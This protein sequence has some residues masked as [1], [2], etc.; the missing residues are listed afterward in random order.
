MFVYVVELND[1]IG[2]D[3]SISPD[4]VSS[5][6][7]SQQTTRPAPN[8]HSY[9]VKSPSRIPLRVHLPNEHSYS[10]SD[11][12]VRKSKTDKVE[13]RKKD[14]QFSQKFNEKCAKFSKLCFSYRG[15]ENQCISND[16]LVALQKS[17]QQ[18]DVNSLVSCIFSSSTLRQA[19]VNRQ[20]LDIQNTAAKL[21]RRKHFYVSELMKKTFQDLKHLDWNKIV[22]EMQ[23]MFPDLF[24]QLL[25]MMLDDHD[26]SSYTSIQKVIPRL[27]LVYGILMQGRNMELSIIQRTMSMLLFDHICDQKVFKPKYVLN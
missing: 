2:S 20:K 25:G 27:G 14:L 3:R 7:V 10:R 18:K 8:D 15:Q 12:N 13:H 17:C 23:E 1:T 6:S 5:S 22:G 16:D 4:V 26:I 9:V 24:V 19:V 11:S 21:N